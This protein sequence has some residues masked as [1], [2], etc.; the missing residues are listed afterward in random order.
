MGLIGTENGFCAQ[1]AVLWQLIGNVLLIFKIVIPVILIVI[2]I[3]T[4]G[5]AVI[6][7]D[8]KDM[9][10]GVNSMV[11]K[12]LVAVLIFFIPNIV[13]TLFGIVSGFNELKSDYNVCQKCISHPKGDYC[14]S[15]VIAMNKGAY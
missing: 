5:K 7:T 13:T 10:N 2:G 4:L 8:E 12:F 11:K 9:K 15:K 3:I 6:S 14:E 1:T